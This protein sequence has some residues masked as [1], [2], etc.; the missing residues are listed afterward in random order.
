DRIKNKL[1]TIIPKGTTPIARTLQAAAGDFTPCL[2]CRNVIILITD[3]LEE[4]KGDPCAVSKELQKK[5]IF[6]KPFIIGIGLKDKS[7]LECA[8]NYFDAEN[9]E[10]FKNILNVIITQVLNST[11]A[12]VN[13]LDI[14][15]K[16]TETDVNMTF[17]DINTGNIKYNFIHTINDRGNPDTLRIDH[18]PTY[19]IFVHT[20]PP[21]SKDSVKLVQGKHNIVGIDAP[22]G[23]LTLKVQGLND[24]KKTLQCIIR[25]AG[26]MATLNVQEFNQ[27]VKYIVGKYDL[28]VLCLPRLIIKDVKISQSTTTTVEIPQPGIA[29]LIMRTPGIA[30]IF[31][32]DKKELKFVCNINPT[33]TQESFLLEP[34]NYKLVYR[35]RNS[36]EVINTI[37]K[38]FKVEAGVSINI[39]IF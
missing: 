1:K 8:G 17:Y 14:N 6:L 21:V 19:K 3:G 32:I 5:G 20:I 11:T 2:E 28:E 27:T 29:T 30:S 38:T 25:K 16:P 10:T 9:E 37:E 23:Y 35:A 24:Y 7:S 13:L 39:N 31:L 15:G 4:C 12:Q 34:G 36:K 26:E 33:A 18:L 22:Q